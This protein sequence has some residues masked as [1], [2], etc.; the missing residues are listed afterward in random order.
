[1]QEARRRLGDLVKAAERGESTVI[2]RRGKV[3]ARI[4]PATDKPLRGLPDLTEFRETVIMEGCSL[5]DEL[6]AMRG[7]ERE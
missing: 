2:T 6:L 3:V 7:E 5:T 4:A 1:M